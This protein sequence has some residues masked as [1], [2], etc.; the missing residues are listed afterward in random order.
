VREARGGGGGR[1]VDVM[2]QVWLYFRPG[3]RGEEGCPAARKNVAGRILP[4]WGLRVPA[5]CYIK[6]KV[7]GRGGYAR[8]KRYS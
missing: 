8:E 5:V 3:A 2:L 6:K 4:P 7:A 1:T